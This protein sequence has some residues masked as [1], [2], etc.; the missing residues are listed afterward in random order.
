MTTIRRL[1]PTL[2]IALTAACA[3]AP[4]APP[5]ATGAPR[6]PDYP[7]PVIPVGQAVLPD[8]RNR[9]VVGWQRLQAGDLR[10]AS[11][12]FTHVLER[13]PEFYPSRTALGFVELAGQNYR[14]ASE[15][16]TAAIARNEA[17]LPAWLG[18][19][20]ALVALRRDADAIEALERVLA[21]D[22][23]REAVRARLQLVRFR[24][25]PALIEAGR[26]ARQAG[27]HEEA[28]RALEQAL[29]MSPGSTIILH[30]LALVEMDAG[31]L[32]QAEVHAREAV[33][34]EPRTA[35]WHAALGEVLARRGVYREASEAFGRAASLEP[36]PEWRTSRDDLAE[37]A[38]LAELP[39]EFAAIRTAESVTRGQAAAFVGIELE[40]LVA[41]APRRVTSVATDIRS[42][43]AAR[44]ILP[45]T[46]A[47]IMSTYPN[48]T[49]QPGGVMRRGDLAAMAAELVRL[50][51]ANRPELAKWQA[52]RPRFPDLPSTHLAYRGAALAVTA[53]VLETTSGGRFE[54]LRLVTGAEL[55]EL[56]DRIAALES[57]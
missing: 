27:R 6:F 44:W 31:R 52:A 24:A 49:F 22:P 12:D 47:G 41:R 54:P 39:P 43:W 21:F 16:F 40:P 13:A 46:G 50:A 48:H 36:R 2:L 8:L 29:A 10:G 30:E 4:P 57:R 20:D 14:E 34:L 25:V 38:R 11:R 3:S 35:E 17:Y 51:A 37:R 23:S 15:H 53:K 5:R 7:E 9:H 56:V 32:D 26:Q 19:A 42:H 28:E 33:R 55:A 1:L 18:Q 45:V